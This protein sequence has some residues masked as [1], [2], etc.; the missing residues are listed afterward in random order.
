MLVSVTENGFAKSAR[1][2]GYYVAG[3]TGTSQIS[4]SALEEEE[5]GY[6]DK[7]WQSFIGFA[8]AFNPEFI[9][10]VKLNNPKTRTAEYSAVPIF[11]DLAKFIV[12]YY[13]IPPD[14]NGQ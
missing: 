6:S 11:Q 9:I 4:F 2:P 5:R 14:Q 8:P 10:L 1:V 13:Q 7:T 3:K 12:D